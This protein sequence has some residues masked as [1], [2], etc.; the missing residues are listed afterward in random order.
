MAMARKVTKSVQQIAATM[1]EQLWLIQRSIQTPARTASGGE[2]VV[3][4][5]R[6]TNGRNCESSKYD[7]GG[8]GG[9]G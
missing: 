4:R 8:R 1:V 2:G 7:E 9:G 6:T 5:M 3:V